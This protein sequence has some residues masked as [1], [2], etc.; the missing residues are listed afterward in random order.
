[1]LDLAMITPEMPGDW[2][3]RCNEEA[4]ACGCLKSF[5]A[6]VVQARPTWPPDV[7]HNLTIDCQEQQE[8]R[9]EIVSQLFSNHIG[10][11]LWSHP[12]FVCTTGFDIDSIT[13][14]IC[15]LLG[16]WL[17]RIGNSQLALKD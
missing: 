6:L 12:Y 5:N 15:L 11:P 16:I 7:L 9:L 8:D 1:M 13:N 4:L 2:L 14:V 10:A 3:F 17:F